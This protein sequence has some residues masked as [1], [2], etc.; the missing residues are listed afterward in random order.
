MSFQE[1]NKILLKWKFN[2]NTEVAIKIGIVMII[3]MNIAKNS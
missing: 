2:V 1:K 3:I